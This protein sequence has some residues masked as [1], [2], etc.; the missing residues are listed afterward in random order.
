MCIPFVFVVARTLLLLRSVLH[1]MR[2]FHCGRLV[3]LVSLHTPY[4]QSAVFV[5]R[6]GPSHQPPCKAGR[7]FNGLGASPF[8]SAA[9][10]DPHAYNVPS[11]HF[12]STLLPSCLG[13]DSGSCCSVCCS[14]PDEDMHRFCRHTLAPPVARLAS[15]QLPFDIH[16]P[17]LAPLSIVMSVHLDGL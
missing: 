16:P 4:P 13:V 5:R 8:Q 14:C 3:L 6:L 12:V 15:F 1:L 17:I 9:V 10:S 11:S 2:V 7:L